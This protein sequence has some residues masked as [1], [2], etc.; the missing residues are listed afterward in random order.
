MVDVAIRSKEAEPLT[1]KSSDEVAQ[2]FQKIYQRSPLTCPELLQVDPGREF[3]GAVTK[4]ME[5]HK[6]RIRR[7]RVKIHRDQAIVERF[8]RTLG[9]RLFGYQY[10]VEMR[11]SE[12]QRSTAWVQRLPE[13][14]AALN[15]EVTSLTG[16]KPAVAIKEKSVNSKPSAHYL[17]PV[18]KKETILPPLVRVRYYY[19]PGELEGGLKRATDPT[20]MVF[21]NFATSKDLLLYYYTICVMGLSEASFKKNY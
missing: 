17:R 7:G 19:H 8:N 11:L 6:T 2:S 20:D 1:S 12:G 14:V 4:L 18:G 5:N 21:K 16:K 10:V 13:V 15:N 9:E 3:M